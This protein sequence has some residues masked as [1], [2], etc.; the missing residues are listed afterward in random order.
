MKIDYKTYIEK[1]KKHIK[2]SIILL[3]IIIIILV[4]FLVILNFNF[5]I[6]EQ[7]RITLTPEYYE[8]ASISS[9]NSLNTA[10]LDVDVQLYNKFVCNAVCNYT[11]ID[12]SHD[13]LLYNG[14]FNSKMY[15]NKHQSFDISLNDYGYGTNIYVYDIKCINIKTTLCPTTSEAVVRKSLLTVKYSPTLEQFICFE[16]FKR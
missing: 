16:L 8:K 4:L 6:G 12:L 2:W 9:N 15:K 13:L 7:L 1:N 14:S 5:M 10:S 3:V 11:V